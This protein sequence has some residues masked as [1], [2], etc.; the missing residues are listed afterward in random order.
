[1]PAV[2]SDGSVTG[3]LLPALH[4]T[5]EIDQTGARIRGTNIRP[6][7]VMIL[8]NNSRSTLLI[9]LKEVISRSI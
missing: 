2:Y 3:L 5:N 9:T 8:P 1:M 6:T 4:L 7:S